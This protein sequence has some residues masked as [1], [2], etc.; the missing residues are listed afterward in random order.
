VKLDGSKA[1]RYLEDCN[2]LHV[3]GALAGHFLSGLGKLMRRSR[4]NSRPMCSVGYAL[5]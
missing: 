1:R 5:T 4:G 3:E 2:C